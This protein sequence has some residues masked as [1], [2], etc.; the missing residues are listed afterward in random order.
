MRLKENKRAICLKSYITPAEHTRIKQFAQQAGL[1]VSEY[2]R[3]IITGTKISS[4]VDQ[5]AFLAALK[6]NADLGRLGG[7]FKYFLSD[8]GTFADPAEVRKLL[9]EIEQRQKELRPIIQ[10]IRA[11]I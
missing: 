8:G 9:G 2:T 3:R 11:A 10:K 7:F 6:V 4:R 1:S 5:A